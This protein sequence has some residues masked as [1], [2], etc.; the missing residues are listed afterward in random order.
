MDLRHKVLMISL[1]CSAWEEAVER[2][3]KRNK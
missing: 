3:K 2:E 1:I